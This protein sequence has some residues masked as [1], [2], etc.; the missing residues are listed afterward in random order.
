MGSFMGGEM[1]DKCHL[2]L[3]EPLLTFSSFFEGFG[4]RDLCEHTA[5]I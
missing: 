2:S 4:E 1:S 5:G 3:A